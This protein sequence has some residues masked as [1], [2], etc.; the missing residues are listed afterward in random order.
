MTSQENPE[1]CKEIFS[2]LS[3][4]LNLELPP[5]ACRAIDDHLAGCPPCIDF[6]ES[7][8]ST[9]ALCR[10]YNPAELPPAIAERAKSELLEAYRKT[11]PRPLTDL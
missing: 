10:Q 11:F 6:V 9:V 5:D 4:Y 2:L 8:R 3:D 1:R 7:L